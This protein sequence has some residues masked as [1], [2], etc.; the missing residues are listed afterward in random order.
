MSEPAYETTDLSLAAFLRVQGVELGMRR[1]ADRVV[2]TAEEDLRPYQERFLLR[3]EKVVALQYAR[4]IKDLKDL[5]FLS[6]PDA[7]SSA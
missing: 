3:Q 2:W 6:G 5:I 4:A 1:D 7:R